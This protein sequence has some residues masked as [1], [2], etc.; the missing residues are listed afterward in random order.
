MSFEGFDGSL[1]ELLQALRSG[2]LT[3]QQCDVDALVRDYLRYY[4]R[5]AEESLE[6]ATETLPLVAR[7]LEL[8]TRLLLPRPPKEPGEEAEEEI[9]TTLEA[10]ALLEELDEAISFLRRRRESRR[11]MLPAQAPVPDYPRPMRPL[12]VAV[13]HLG[14]LASRYTGRNYFE[15]TVPRLTISGAINKLSQY[16]RRVGRA[17]L[18]DTVSEGGWPVLT[19]HF[20]AMLELIKEGKVH[21]RQDEPYGAITLEPSYNDEHE[22]VPDVA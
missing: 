8:K 14:E 12:R 9:E 17:L 4:R 15:L 21:A 7:V 18:H 2:R 22:Q 10:V 13:S 5:L 6:L 3:P 11:L 19:V 1:S 16:L 20:A